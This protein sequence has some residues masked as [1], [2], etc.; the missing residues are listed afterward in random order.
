MYSYIRNDL[1]VEE[2]AYTAGLFDGDGYVTLSRG[3]RRDRSRT[4][5]YRLLIGVG[6]TDQRLTNWFHVRWG[7]Y[8][9]VRE[10][11]ILGLKKPPAETGIF[12]W[13]IGNRAAIRFL[14]RILPYL[15]AK[16]EQAE[17]AID[18]STTLTNGG[19]RLSADEVAL[20][21]GYYLAMKYAHGGR[22]SEHKAELRVSDAPA[23]GMQVLG[24]K[25]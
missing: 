21:E 15:V 7:G 6:N 23:H 13:T 1:T 2:I 3:R 5:S 22:K 20:R 24:G 18:F 17:I 25:A 19:R 16:K 4:P 14:R 9:Q 12:E 8:H 11:R 10:R